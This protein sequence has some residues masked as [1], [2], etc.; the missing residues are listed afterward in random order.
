MLGRESEKRELLELLEREES[1]FCAVYGRRRVG[2]TYLIRETFHY[3]FTFQH[4]GAAN[5]TTKDQLL[6]FRDSLQ[7]SGLRRCKVP[8]S[9]REAFLRL[10]ELI[11]Q[12][13]D[14][15][16]IIFIDELQWMDTPRSHFISAL[17][18]FWN[19]WATARK[20]KD[21]V[22]IVCGS[23]TSWITTNILRNHGGLYGRLTQQIYL[24]PF[25]L[26]ECEKY[27]QFN[28]IEL[29]RKEL[30]ELYMIMGGIPYYWSFLQRGKSMAQNIDDIFFAP[31]A[32]LK[33]EFEDLYA[34]L[35]KNKSAYIS[36]VTAL[37][38]KKS[39]LTRD[40]IVENSGAENNGKLTDILKDLEQC[41]FVRKYNIYQRKNRGAVYQLMDNFSLFYFRYMANNTQRDEHFWS[42]SLSSQQHIV[43]A[44]LAFERVCMQHVAQIK[45]A[46]GI[47]GVQTD[48]WTWST[49]ETDVHSAAQI[50]MLLDRRDG[51]INICEM[52][53]SNAPFTIDKNYDI[54]LRQ[55]MST[56]R[57]VSQTTKA[58]HLTLITTYGL[59]RNKYSGIAQSEVTMDDLF[60]K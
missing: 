49:P 4:T 9:W 11:D 24:R 57:E 27:A 25:T 54:Q 12:S 50:D 3:Q 42:N 7:S 28:G 10:E 21:I 40:E 2:K 37:G 30:V 38:K 43:W 34:S 16:K 55:K 6:L 26:A 19:G 44:G 8:R 15:K 36:V 13:K 31:S 59:E 56:F 18:H 47:S 53:F 23:S 5:S 35:F 58:I 48:Y 33:N 60:V 1:Q 32:K 20:E 17:E 45:K 29:S 41:D 14:E 52:K 39:G 22:L 51:I 46:L